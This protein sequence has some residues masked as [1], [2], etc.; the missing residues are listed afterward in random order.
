MARLRERVPDSRLIIAGDGPG[1]S[2]IE[3]RV[4]RLGL[5]DRCW[6]TGYLHDEEMERRLAVAWV[7]AVPSRYDEPFPNTTIE[8]MMRGTA[9]VASAVGGCPEIVRHGVT[10]LLVP[11]GDPGA[12]ADALETILSDRDLAARM[13]AAA[14]SAAVQDFGADRMLDAF[15]AAYH[16]LLGL[17]APTPVGARH[18]ASEPAGARLTPPSAPPPT[19]GV[20][21]GPESPARRADHRSAR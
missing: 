6:L 2:A 1:R 19:P 13:G 14:R 17:P 20:H 5:Q 15:E 3:K 16:S 18:E 9:V 4:A 8:A 21:T 11:P 10:G 12:L 7:N